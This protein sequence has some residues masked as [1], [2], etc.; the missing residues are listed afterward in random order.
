MIF[1]LFDVF[2]YECDSIID[3]KYQTIYD[4]IKFDDNFKIKV[5]LTQSTLGKRR[6]GS[7]RE[8]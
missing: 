4:C 6:C 1:S 5:T 8:I 2:Y 7:A 3:K